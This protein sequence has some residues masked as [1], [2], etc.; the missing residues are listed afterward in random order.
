MD[1]DDHEVH[2]AL[3]VGSVGTAV[4]NGRAMQSIKA[5]SDMRIKA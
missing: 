2:D 4:V 3:S 1:V 5:V